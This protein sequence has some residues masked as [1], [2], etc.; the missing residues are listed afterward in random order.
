VRAKLFLF[1]ADFIRHHPLLVLSVWMTAAGGSLL[2]ASRLSMMTTRTDLLSPDNRYVTRYTNFTHE[3]GTANNI[4]FIIESPT[5][6]RSKSCAG[7]LAAEIGKHPEYI[8]DVLYRLDLD[9]IEKQIFHHLSKRQ[10]EAIDDY[11]RGNSDFLF[12]LAGLKNLA[13]LFPAVGELAERRAKENFTN[14]ATERELLALT[15]LLESMN[16]YLW[17]NEPG[18]IDFLPALAGDVLPFG[19]SGDPD[20]FIVG[21]NKETV[22]VVARPN[23]ER[24]DSLD[25]L[26]PMMTA[27][28]QAR[29]KVLKEYPDAT[30]GVT[31]LATFSYGDLRVMEDEM[32]LLFLLAL[33]VNIILFFLFFRYPLHIFFTG[34][35]LLLALA[36]TFGAAK[37]LIGHLNIMSSVFAITMVSLGIDF[38][39][40]FISRFHLEIGNTGGLDEAMRATF[41]GLGPPI[42]TGALTTAAAFFLLALTDFR[43]LAELGIISGCG[44]LLCLLSM[45]TALP[46][47]ICLEHKWRL[48]GIRKRSGS[49]VPLDR[50]LVRFADAAGTNAG[51]ITTV[52]A[53]GTLL[54]CFF[55]PQVSFDYNFLNIQPKNSTTAQ[56]ESILMERTGLA[57]AFNVILED[58]LQTLQEK[59]ERLR[60]LPAVGRV[61]SATDL[62]PVSHDEDTETIKDIREQILLIERHMNTNHEPASLNAV[63]EQMGIMKEGME[64]AL[65]MKA[66]IENDQ[67]IRTLEKA[68]KNTETFLQNYAQDDDA[69]AENKLQDFSRDFF[70]YFAAQMALL[71]D[72]RQLDDLRFSDYPDNISTR[73]VGRTGKYA[74]Y[75]FPS[76]SIWDK[77]FL[78]K[79]NQDTLDVAPNAAGTALFAQELL[80]ITGRALRQSGLLVLF[81]VVLLVFLDF[82][83]ISH[84]A[85]ALSPL[86]IGMVWMLGLMKVF[87][88]QYNPLNIMVVP[89]MLGIGVDN[90][91]H[92]VHRF[93]DTGNARMAIVTSGY[94]IMVSSLTTIAGFACLLLSTHRGL[95]SL[96]QLLVLGMS[97]C[98]AASILVLPAV[99]TIIQPSR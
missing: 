25:F 27:V 20:G 99:L 29:E 71:S 35:S 88:W 76:R 49:T 7:A 1:I 73:F 28:E 67:I 14:P 51:L 91:V 89:V 85:L 64:R 30:I 23:A 19:A 86:A 77:D 69:P 38:G 24:E 3:F 90:G 26:K 9:N 80:D 37:I 83:K 81:A 2:L 66:L 54:S 21:K 33:V 57:P 34:I 6:E 58:D 87:G 40:H 46:A 32:P 42:A 36:C 5:L 94:A 61:D 12:R 41:V 47:M 17:R 60:K 52:A 65:G 53:V 79:F 82:R 18:R 97:A 63:A 74:A 15:A 4:Y 78:D 56:Y 50:V 16:S 96:S 45:L 92:I 84:A 11:L 44:I 48:S 70:S 59:V 31:G 8:R 95:I 62:V 10:L 98:L 68:K 22:I 93:L 13:N 55:A 39:V 43:G 72:N 75:V